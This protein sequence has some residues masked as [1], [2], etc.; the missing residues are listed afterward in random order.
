MKLSIAVVTMNRAQQLVEALNSCVVCKI[1]QD[2]EFIIIDNASTDNTEEVIKSFFDDNNYKFYYEKLN[3]NIGCGN[4]RNYAYQKSHGNYVYFLDDDAYI[5]TSKNN[6]FFEKAIDILDS[7]PQIKTLTTQIYDLVW[8][9]NRVDSAGPK[10]SENLSKVY[11]FCGGSHYL[12]RDFFCESKPYYANKYGYEEIF[13]SLRVYDAGY[14]NAFAE[15]LLVIHNPKV[16]KWNETQKDGIRLAAMG[17]AQ[18]YMMRSALFP[19][20]LK[21]INFLAFMARLLP[22]HSCS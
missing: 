14:I 9:K 22:R 8:K 3:E 18:T 4:G 17:L 13:P 16:N 19:L 21:P 6:F 2:T 15:D 7:N 12:R 1:P 11:M 20:L 5:D 10:I